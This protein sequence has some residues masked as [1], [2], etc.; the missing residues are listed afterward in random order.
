MSGR[1]DPDRILFETAHVRVG[2]FRCAVD[3]PAFADS[4]PIRAHCFVFPRTPVVIQ[5]RDGRPFAADPTLVTLYNKGQEYRRRR[6]SPEGDRCDWYA[7]SNDVL[8]DAVTEFDRHAADDDRRPIRFA[9]AQS[10]AP[11]YLTQRQLFAAIDAR[12]Q[13]DPLMVEETVFDLLA[14]VLARAYASRRPHETL[15]TCAARARVE[16]AAEWMGRHFSDAA[17]L[18]D[19]ALAVDASVF[20]LCRSFRRV[21]G[22]TL[23]EYRDHLRLRTALERLEDGRCDL[24]QLAL[25]LGY[26]SHSHLTASYRRVF[27]EPPS[28]TRRSLRARM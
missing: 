19:I 24:T 7:V 2:A 3:H 8:R 21:T 16:A 22:L 11:T 10:D 28:V 9:F 23:H 15:P 26:S 20:H 1:P 5:H 25:D 14:R 27:G 6:L 17:S 18:A 4:G 13:L 12:R